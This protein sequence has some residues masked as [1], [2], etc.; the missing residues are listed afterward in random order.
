MV[1]GDI[2]VDEEIGVFDDRPLVA[3]L[4]VMA[5]FVGGGEGLAAGCLGDEPIRDIFALSQL[6]RGG[7]PPLAG[8][9]GGGAGGLGE[10]EDVADG[11]IAETEA[12]AFLFGQA[13]GGDV[14]IEGSEREAAMG[15]AL[16]HQRLGA[17]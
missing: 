17:L 10:G 13:L 2:L 6:N 7:H 3:V 1:E 15:A 14:G 8:G 5:V 16:A 4:E 9:G 12:A 11:L